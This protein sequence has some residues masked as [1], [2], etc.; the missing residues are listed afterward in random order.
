MLGSCFQALLHGLA[1]RRAVPRMFKLLPSAMR[2]LAHLEI[3]NDEVVI[4]FSRQL[5][6][7]HSPAHGDVDENS[8]VFHTSSAL[9]NAALHDWVVV[10]IPDHAP[11]PSGYALFFN[12]SEAVG[13]W[14]AC[15]VW[16]GGLN[17]AMLLCILAGVGAPM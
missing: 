6:L 13:V 11:S 15:Q 7:V 8:E 4:P 14:L 2:F 9:W 5:S 12:P 10:D 16:K 3:A 1:F 17:D